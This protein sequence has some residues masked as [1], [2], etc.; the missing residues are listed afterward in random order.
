MLRF[1]CP[2]LLWRLAR[3][4]VSPLAMGAPAYR[5]IQLWTVSG[6]GTVIVRG[7][8]NAA[9]HCS[10]FLQ[11]PGKAPPQRGD[12]VLVWHGAA[13]G[14]RGFSPGHRWYGYVLWRGGG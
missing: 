1:P 11:P 10:W 3:V 12:T 6:V 14:H 2:V 9:L 4:A 7:P 8:R 5:S 13:L